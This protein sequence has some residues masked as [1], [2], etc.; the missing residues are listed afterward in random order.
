MDLR[1]ATVALLRWAMNGLSE[2][3]RVKG[4]CDTSPKTTCVIQQVCF[5][6]CWE[7]SRKGE[8]GLIAQPRFRFRRY[9]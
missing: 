8:E 5:Y 9:R 2:T 4:K 1:M 6:A 3:R 7:H